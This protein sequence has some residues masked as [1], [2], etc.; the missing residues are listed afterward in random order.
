MPLE[1]LKLIDSKGNE[2]VFKITNKVIE[3]LDNDIISLVTKALSDAINNSDT[4]VVNF[5]ISWM[6]IYLKDRTELA[7]FW[8]RE[9]RLFINKEN[10]ENKETKTNEKVRKHNLVLHK[11]RHSE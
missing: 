9:V 4:E 2:I 8:E 6:T 3:P 7:M 5:L 10:K 11:R 1:S